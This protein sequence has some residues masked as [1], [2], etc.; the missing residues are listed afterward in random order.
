[1]K[2]ERGE[3]ENDRELLIRAFVANNQIHPHHHANNLSYGQRRSQ[4]IASEDSDPS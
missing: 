2:G 1:M 4:H 3:C